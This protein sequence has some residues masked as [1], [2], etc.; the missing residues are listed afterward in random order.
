MNQLLPPPELDHEPPRNLTPAQR[1][2]LWAAGM[3]LAHEIL[4]AGLRHKVGPDGDVEAA[5]REWYEREME[6]HD[7]MMRQML[8][9]LSRRE[10]RHGR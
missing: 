1:I 6:D 2:E 8:E 7:A 4:M 3:D 9:N 5:Y 10:R